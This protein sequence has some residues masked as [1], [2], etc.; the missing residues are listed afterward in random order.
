MYTLMPSLDAFIAVSRF[1]LGARPL[2][3]PNLAT[4]PRGWLKA[5]LG[6]APPPVA[7][8]ARRPGDEI[9]GDFQAQLAGDKASRPMARRA[10]R[11]HYFAEV[12]ARVFAQIESRRPF[13]ERL[14]AFWSNHF[15]ISMKKARIL[16]IA[17]AFEREAIRPHVLGRFA[18][19][20]LAV[21]QHPAMLIYLDNVRSIGPNSKVGARRERGLNEN[22]AREILELHT[23]GVD[24]GYDQADVVALAKIITGWSVGRVGT[25]ESGAF[26]FY[27]DAHE[28]GAKTLLGVRYA[29][30]GIDEGKR[31]LRALAAH[32]STARHVATK[33][34]RHFV[35]DDPDPGTVERLAAVFRETEGDLARVAAAL[36]DLPA[37]WARPLGKFKMPWEF[38]TSS[39]RATGFAGEAKQLVA[40]NKLLGQ[41]LWAP[42]S[43]AGWPDLAAS[44]ITPNGMF[45]RVE[46]AAAIAR[47]FGGRLDARELAGHVIGPVMSSR[48]EE[49]IGAAAG[50]SD[51]LVLLFASPEF[52]RR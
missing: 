40:M 1:G 49:A 34:A 17:G 3:L 45:Q 9:L 4:D 51:G 44:W 27:A 19:M 36:V 10:Y 11:D 6:P 48:T 20:L 41:P 16:G 18:D 30:S 21:V 32:P 46:V 28:P 13:V 23:L 7:V 8:A 50:P 38:I 12:G 39:L 5:Q 14:V 47:R 35:A 43:P 42:P 37:A 29:E 31:A 24:G 33:L 22:L 52:Q 2:E 26:R 25:D 15:A